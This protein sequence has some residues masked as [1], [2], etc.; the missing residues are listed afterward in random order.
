MVEELILENGILIYQTPWYLRYGFINLWQTTLIGVAIL[1]I[2]EWGL[3][4]NWRKILM[5]TWVYA[6]TIVLYLEHIAMV[7]AGFLTAILFR[8]KKYKNLKLEHERQQWI[9]DAQKE[10]LTEYQKVEMK[11]E[12]A[13]MKEERSEAEK[14]RIKANTPEWGLKIAKLFGDTWKKQHF[15]KEGIL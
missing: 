2:L 8:Q 15:P 13:R 3:Q 11:E 1:L 12:Q 6:K 10:A 14:E 5:E 9:I 7:V 4:Q